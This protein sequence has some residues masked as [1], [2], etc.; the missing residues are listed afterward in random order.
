MNTIGHVAK[1]LGV[2]SHTLRYYEKIGLLPPIN[3]DTAGRRHFSLADIEQIKFIKRAQ[4][5][6][7]SL[8]EIR[9]LLNLDKLPS[10]PKAEAQALVTGKLADVEENLQ[11]LKKLKVDLGAMLQQCLASSS[12]EDC[13]IISGFKQK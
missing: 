11:E 3:K 5:M 4:R 7:F 6:R 13:P 9:Q 8:E 12:D 2:S 10:V 1:Q